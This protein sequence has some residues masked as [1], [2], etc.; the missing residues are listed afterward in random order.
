MCFIMVMFLE[1]NYHLCIWGWIWKLPADAAYTNGT[2]QCSVS[3]CILYP[4]LETEQTNTLDR[5]LRIAPQYIA[6]VGLIYNV[7]RRGTLDS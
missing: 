4:V 6:F 1:M 3:E 2:V 5:D 7:L